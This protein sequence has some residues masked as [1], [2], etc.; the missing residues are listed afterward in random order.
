M[1]QNSPS[2]FSSGCLLIHP[3]CPA[4]YQGAGLSLMGP[5]SAGSLPC[6]LVETRKPLWLRGLAM[7]KRRSVIDSVRDYF[8]GGFF[9]QGKTFRA[10]GELLQAQDFGGFLAVCVNT[11]WLKSTIQ[12]WHQ[13][14]WCLLCVSS[15]TYHRRPLV[16]ETTHMFLPSVCR[17]CMRLDK[18]SQSRAG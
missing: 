17:C 9:T 3:I 18:P 1:A 13:W 4:F 11:Y 10:A 14:R 2:P 16:Y 15:C 8:G 6:R 5:V 12:R 7:E